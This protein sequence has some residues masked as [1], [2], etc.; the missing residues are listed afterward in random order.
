M[1]L[2]SYVG[3]IFVKGKKFFFK[4]FK[5]FKLELSLTLCLRANIISS[6]LT[7]SLAAKT[8]FVIKFFFVIVAKE[9]KIYYSKYIQ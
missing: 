3:L 7:V 9:T 2:V 8:W 5:T 4:H 1:F 6:S